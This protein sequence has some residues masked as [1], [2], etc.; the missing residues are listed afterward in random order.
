MLPIIIV[1]NSAEVLFFIPVIM[2]LRK[3]IE[4]S[5]YL[6]P[7]L[8]FLALNF[9]T[10]FSMTYFATRHINNAWIGRIY[11]PIEF[12]LFSIVFFRMVPK[13]QKKIIIILG[14]VTLLFYVYTDMFLRINNGA[15]FY[16][17]SFSSLVLLFVSARFMVWFVEK[18]RDE[19][20]NDPRF[21]ITIAI[22]LYEAMT[23]IVYI[24]FSFIDFQLPYFINLLAGFTSNLLYVYALFIF[25]K[26]QMLIAGSM[27]T[28]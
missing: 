4:F 18:G 3:K 20:F 28:S 27:A 9:I 6:K 22:L 23:A 17:M 5:A 24:L 11:Q 8:I 7:F 14:A 16:G 10:D 25:Y 1:Y 15:N 13:H 19:I 12:L 21:F 2:I 26:R